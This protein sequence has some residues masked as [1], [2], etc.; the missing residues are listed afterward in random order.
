MRT[1]GRR[2]RRKALRRGRWAESVCAWWL[3]LHG[4]RVLGRNV[5][6]PVGEIDILARRGATLAV[7]EVKSRESLAEAAEALTGAQRR[8]IGR[9]A[10]S[11]LAA[12]PDW[13]E[14]SVRFDAMLVRPWRLP[15]HIMDAWR[16]DPK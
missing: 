1:R 4:Y 11:L 12:R 6:T 7:V 16:E 13:A 14:L 15:Q 2:A 8:R 3:R 10:E 5:R 9:A